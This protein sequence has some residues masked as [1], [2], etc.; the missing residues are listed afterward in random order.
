MVLPGCK[1]QSVEKEKLM[2]GINPKTGRKLAVIV[3][4]EVL[5]V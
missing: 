4:S 1:G 5:S 2:K 3:N